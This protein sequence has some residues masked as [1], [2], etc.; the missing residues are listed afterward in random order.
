MPPKKQD[1][2]AAARR[3]KVAEDKTFGLKNKNKSKKVQ[4]YV[5]SVTRSQAQVAAEKAS[6]AKRAAKASQ[7]A[8]E[9]EMAQMFKTV[10]KP[11]KQGMDPKSVLCEYFKQGLC[12]RGDKCKFSHDAS[13][14]RKVAKLDIYQDPRWID[15]EDKRPNRTDIVCKYF[16]DAVE[17][18]K[19]GPLWVCPNNG[20]DCQYNH[21][22]PQGFVLQ[23][24]KKLM[25][26]QEG[27]DVSLEEQI[28][29]DRAALLK[30]SDLTPAT[31]ESFE[32]WKIAQKEKAEAEVK[33]KVKA[34][35]DKKAMGKMGLATGL[36][37]RDL[38]T[39]DPSLFVDDLDAAND[40]ELEIVAEEEEDADRADAA[41]D[42]KQQLSMVG[43]PS[44]FLADDDLPD[45]DK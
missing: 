12:L 3:Q 39:F 11:A 45:D 36:S 8:L 34:A 42:E 38:F 1:K 2:A 19:Y 21:C 44:L 43:D 17:A 25:A 31:K 20:K 7:Q 28:E 13:Q 35:M 6:A 9:R 14:V 40:D 26:E 27:D 33:A 29:I 4:A 32:K 41:D 37:G 16:L 22:L 23:R 24:D 10:Q 30:R 5:Q 18:R 15:E